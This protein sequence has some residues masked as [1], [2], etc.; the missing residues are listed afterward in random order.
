MGAEVAG[1][2]GGTAG[3]TVFVSQTSAFLP[4]GSNMHPAVDPLVGATVVVG[5]W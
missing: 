4:E 1:K 2:Y 3:I 5:M